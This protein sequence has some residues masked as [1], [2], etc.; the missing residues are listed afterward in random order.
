MYRVRHFYFA[1]VG[2][3]NGIQLCLSQFYTRYV[4]T[5]IFIALETNKVRSHMPDLK[6]FRA[7]QAVSATGSI[8]QAAQQLEWSTPTVDYHLAALEQE[9]GSA[10]VSR[11]SR[12]TTLTGVGK[13]LV[14]R[15][16]ELLALAD[17]AIVDA[18]DLANLTTP[19][20]RLGMF[21]TAAA[22]LLPS[23]AKDLTRV[24]IELEAR[25][26]EATSLTELLRTREIDA[27][28]T[29][30]VPSRPFT[31]GRD[32]SISHVHTDPLLFTMPNDHA[33]ARKQTVTVTDLAALH[34]EHWIIGATPNDVLD[35]EMEAIIS[36]H[37]GD[38]QVAIRT[39]DLTVAMSMV[40]AGLAVALIP[41]L[42]VD[43]PPKG[44]TFRAVN[45]PRLA[46]EIHLISS[47]ATRAALPHVRNA[48]E[49]AMRSVAE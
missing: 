10:V 22:K 37:S 2:R 36:E 28:L 9:A 42:A 29:Y 44:I 17:R 7:L 27:A 13:L 23:I 35:E 43:H 1:R 26:E 49:N 41:E 4:A 19:K 47:L 48:V 32:L 31:R 20:L 34:A 45:E 8:S 3:V 33:L 11:S 24:G 6:Q 39:D 18:R 40:A 30:T 15:A 25:V 16:D 21:P 14:D 46:R 12:G 5:L 38:M